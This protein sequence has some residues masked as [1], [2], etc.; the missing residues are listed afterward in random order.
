[1]GPLAEGEETIPAGD[2][3]APLLLP[4]ANGAAEELAGAVPRLPVE[5]TDPLP[6]GPTTAEALPLYV[7]KVEPEIS[8]AE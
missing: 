3:E 4:V 5:K 1:M 8:G 6:V 2:D 7:G